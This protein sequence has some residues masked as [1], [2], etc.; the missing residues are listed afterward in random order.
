MEKLSLASILTLLSSGDN[1]L[2]GEDI[3]NNL[4]RHFLVQIQQRSVH[5]HK[6]CK[7][8]YNGLLGPKIIASP[9]M[10]R[11]RNICSSFTFM[12]PWCHEHYC[13]KLEAHSS[14]SMSMMLSSAHVKIAVQQPSMQQL[15]AAAHG[16]HRI[17][18]S[19]CRF[20]VNLQDPNT[21]RSYG[22]E[23]PQVLG[24]SAQRALLRLKIACEDIKCALSDLEA[25]V[26]KVGKLVV[27]I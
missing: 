12:S 16:V 6:T 17:S 7:W 2:G 9:I 25:T 5:T 22:D 1:H 11:L 3:T 10:F 13:K 19:H 8:M 24:A 18:I 4:V 15:R 23:T 20:G 21:F 26:K 14:C 27:S